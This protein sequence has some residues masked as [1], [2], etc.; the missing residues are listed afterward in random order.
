MKI[1][2]Q[3]QQQIEEKLALVCAVTETGAQAKYTPT[4]THTN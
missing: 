2:D 4:H 1:S 3:Q